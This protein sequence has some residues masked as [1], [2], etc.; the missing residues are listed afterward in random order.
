MKSKILNSLLIISS[1][2]GYLEWGGKNHTFLFEVEGEIIFKLCNNLNSIIHPF[3]ILPLI[4]QFL[5]II[6]LVQKKPNKLLTYIGIACLGLLLV[7]MFIIGLISLNYKIIISTVPFIVI[8]IL[9]IIHFKNLKKINNS[10]QI[11]L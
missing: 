7:F 5:L 1:F 11:G 3:T 8:A 4:G 6:T 9:N 2:F 10:S